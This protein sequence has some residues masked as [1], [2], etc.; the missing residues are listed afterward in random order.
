MEEA[1]QF[2]ASFFGSRAIWRSFTYFTWHRIQYSLSNEYS[3]SCEYIRFTDLDPL[4]CELRVPMTRESPPPHASQRYR[5]TDWLP[6]G[7]G[8]GCRMACITKAISPKSRY[9]PSYWRSPVVFLNFG[10]CNI[11]NYWMD[12]I[13]STGIWKK[14]CLLFEEKSFNPLIPR[15]GGWWGDVW[16]PLVSDM[17]VQ[18]WRKGRGIPFQGPKLFMDDV[19]TGF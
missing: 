12:V 2:G 16:N 9:P 7:V 1:V 10:G 4:V 5:C 14:I 18:S 8:V 11:E 15:V 3:E 17:D 19:R 6:C 13:P